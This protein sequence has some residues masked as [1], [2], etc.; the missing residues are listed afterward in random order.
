M[1]AIVAID[2]N[3]G[4]GKEGQLLVKLKADMEW[5]KN[6][7]IN[8]VVI[9][10]RKTMESIGRPLPNRLNI[11]LT[12][13]FTINKPGYIFLHSIE[14]LMTFLRLKRISTEDCFVIGGG[15]IYKALE[16][17]IAYVYVN[18]I[19][20]TF[21]SD[22][23]FPIS[24]TNLQILITSPIQEENGLKFEFR[25]YRNCRLFLDFIEHMMKRP[26]HMSEINLAKSVLTS[27]NTTNTALYNLFKTQSWI[28]NRRIFDSNILQTCYG[29]CANKTIIDE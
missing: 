3:N 7:T 11:V 18:K 28:K 16:R 26:L 27:D 29:N 15:Q 24:F 19:F 21:D 14:D 20:K 13:N 9:M 25:V 4:I 1:N 12:K 17:Q 23:T 8:K 2:N 6:I 5:F 10:G 22:T